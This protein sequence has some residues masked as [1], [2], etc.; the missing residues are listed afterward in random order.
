VSTK[1]YN[2]FSQLRSIEDIFG[3][4]HIGDAQQPQVHP[5]GSDVYTQPAG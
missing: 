1:A 5:F 3:L 2:H 4:R